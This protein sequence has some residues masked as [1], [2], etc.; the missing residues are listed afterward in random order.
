M[1]QKETLHH[2]AAEISVIFLKKELRGGHRFPVLL[3]VL[4]RE[5][6]GLLY[7]FALKG[8]DVCEIYGHSV[9]CG[10]PFAGS[11]SKAH[12]FRSRVPVL[13]P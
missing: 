1:S 7:P 11:S 8:L 3:V 5:L 4:Q 6:L 12:H 10:H 9:E 13:G 2:K